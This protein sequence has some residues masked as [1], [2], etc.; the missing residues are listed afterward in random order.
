MIITCDF[1]DQQASRDGRKDLHYQNI[2]LPLQC[3]AGV[4][5][6]THIPIYPYTLVHKTKYGGS[7]KQDYWCSS[8]GT[9]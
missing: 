6:L 9:Y 5:S 1:N 8:F 2:M 4:Q 7:G 3:N